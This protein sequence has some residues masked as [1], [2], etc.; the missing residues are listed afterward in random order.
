MSGEDE[1]G[2]GG[3]RDD[4]R[5]GWVAVPLLSVGERQLRNVLTRRMTVRE[6]SVI[7]P[8]K[9]APVPEIVADAAKSVAD[10]N[11]VG[12]RGMSSPG[13]GGRERR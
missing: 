6:G 3:G 8:G 7:C 11:H 9:S 12:E 1:G 2:A 10:V 4:G 5:M 13:D